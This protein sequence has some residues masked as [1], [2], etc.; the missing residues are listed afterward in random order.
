MGRAWYYT[1][2]GQKLG[3]VSSTELKQLAASG[4]LQPTDNVWNDQMDKWVAARSIKN[5]FGQEHALPPTAAPPPVPVGVASP[6]PQGLNDRPSDPGRLERGDTMSEQWYYARDG[7]RHGPVPEEELRQLAAAGKVRPADLI[8][9]EG[10][11][12]WVPA[13]SVQRL[14]AEASSPGAAAVPPPLPGPAPGQASK[15]GL[16]DKIKGQVERLKSQG[17]RLKGRLQSDETKALVHKAKAKWQ[18][19]STPVKAG[20][21]GGV[22]VG[23]FLLVLLVC[24]LPFK[25]FF[26]TSSYS[27]T[28]SEMM[29]ELRACQEAAHAEYHGKTLTVTGKVKQVTLD[30]LILKG[31]DKESSSSVYCKFGDSEFP[32]AAAREAAIR[33][34]GNV[35]PGQSVTVR[36]GFD[37]MTEGNTFVKNCEFSEGRGKSVVELVKEC[38]G[39]KAPFDNKYKGKRLR[40]SGGVKEARKDFDD[41]FIRFETDSDD[42]LVVQCRFKAKYDETLQHLPRGE[43]VVIEGACGGSVF[44]SFTEIKLLDANLISPAKSGGKPGNPQGGGDSKAQ[45]LSGDAE[46]AGGPR[47]GPRGSG[48]PG[49]SAADEFAERLGKLTGAGKSQPNS[50]DA[51]QAANVMERPQPGSP[52]WKGYGAFKLYAIGTNEQF[53]AGDAF[54]AVGKPDRIVK[55][56]WLSTFQNPP[57]NEWQEWVWMRNGVALRCW[58]MNISALREG[59]GECEAKPEDDVTIGS[60]GLLVGGDLDF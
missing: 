33:R 21:A 25:W 3:P 48:S 17:E 49:G 10:M 7:Q 46:A 14:F 28:A 35:K 2:D 38:D 23:G 11:T 37:K 59:R 56:P 19:S 24:V 32:D 4:N 40:L 12:E 55:A 26:G 50:L 45:R 9:K 8:W 31:E 29:K 27:R 43:S 36:C 34:L 52:R 58:V 54:Q 42:E 41:W 60:P 39:F 5:L 20:V 22:A 1:R 13:R 51:N 30:L 16:M 44:A 18:A 6:S 53:R 47:A 57:G 15:P